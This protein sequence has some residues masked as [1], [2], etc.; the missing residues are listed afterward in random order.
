MIEVFFEFLLQI[1]Y[2]K[3]IVKNVHEELVIESNN[4]S[5]PFPLNLNDEGKYFNGNSGFTHPEGVTAYNTASDKI[6]EKVSETAV[7]KSPVL[8]E[9]GI[10]IEKCVRFPTPTLS[11][12][13]LYPTAYP[14]HRLLP[15][16]LPEPTIYPTLPPEPE[17]SIPPIIIDPPEIVPIP[18]YPICPPEYLVQH[19]NGS[20][21]TDSMICLDYSSFN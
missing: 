11:Y 8:V 5:R 16:I 19:A 17:P 14:T 3:P 7:E 9:C 18:P 10:N 1:Y 21:L 20:K 12:P 6:I 15:T 13:T 4:I 2:Q